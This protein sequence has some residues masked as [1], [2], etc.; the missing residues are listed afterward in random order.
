MT[1]AGNQSVAVDLY[2]CLKSGKVMV[3]YPSMLGRNSCGVC[4]AESKWLFQ[5]WESI[6]KWKIEGLLRLKTES[7]FND[8]SRK[9]SE[10][11]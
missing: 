8:S 10:S 9:N 2:K 5:Y 3:L 7:C 6:C 4:E 1:N 11:S